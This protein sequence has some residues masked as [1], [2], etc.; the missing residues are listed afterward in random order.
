MEKK[1]K[2][3]WLEFYVYSSDFFEG[4]GTALTL[5]GN[6]LSFNVNRQ[7]KSNN[8]SGKKG[9]EMDTVDIDRILRST[10]K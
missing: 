2:K 3:H 8:T 6:F 9:R 4:M 7:S 1:V 10:P 5:F